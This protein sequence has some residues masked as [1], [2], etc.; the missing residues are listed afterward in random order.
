MITPEFLEAK[1]RIEAEQ[2]PAGAGNELAQRRGIEPQEFNSVAERV[3]WLLRAAGFRALTMEEQDTLAQFKRA[4]PA[5]YR[6]MVELVDEQFAGQKR[7]DPACDR[8]LIETG[9]RIADR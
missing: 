5:S 8:V 9:R 4:Q 6:R 3:H 7:Q 2:I 1:R